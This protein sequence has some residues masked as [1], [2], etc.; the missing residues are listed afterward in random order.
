MSRHF[1]PV[2]LCVL[3]LSAA[4]C[5][6]KDPLAPEEK[7]EAAEVPVVAKENPALLQQPAEIGPP[8]GGVVA[9][10]E[11]RLRE[12]IKLRDELEDRVGRALGGKGNGIQRQGSRSL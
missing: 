1:L 4:G 3:A 12:F 2:C 6:Q 7:P 11:Q 10:Y 9:D 5:K 8:D